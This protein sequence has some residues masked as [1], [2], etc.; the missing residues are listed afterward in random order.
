MSLGLLILIIAVAAVVLVAA[1]AG[2]VLSGRR[3]PQP[4]NVPG[5]KAAKRK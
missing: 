4:R 2:L 5:I 1:V 3:K